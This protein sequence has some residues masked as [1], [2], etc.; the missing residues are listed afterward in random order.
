MKK[1]FLNQ[2]CHYMLYFFIMLSS[3]QHPSAQGFTNVGTEN[4]NVIYEHL[5]SAQGYGYIIHFVDKK[6]FV[7]DVTSDFC[8]LNHTVMRELNE[9]NFAKDINLI[10]PNVA[11]LDWGAANR[12]I[13]RRTNTLPERCTSTSKS[14]RSSAPFDAQYLFSVYTQTYSELYAFADMVNLKQKIEFWSNK[15]SEATTEEELVEIIGS[16]IT[17]VDDGH[18]ALWDEK[19][20]VLAF[21]DTKF[22]TLRQR[23]VQ[24]QIKNTEYAHSDYWRYK[25]YLQDR[26]ESITEGYF[27]KQTST[28]QRYDNFLF[29]HLPN[30]LRY[31]KIS[32]MSEFSESQTLTSDLNAV[33]EILNLILPSMRESNGI[34]IDLRSNPGGYDLVS[35]KILSYFIDKKLV[36]ASKQAKYLAGFTP[37]RTV[38]VAPAN[39]LPFL[40]P[41]IVL[42]NQFTTSAAEIFVL[43]LK[44]RG[45]VSFYGTRTDGA[46]SDSLIKQ[47]SNGW[48]FSLSNEVY[49][50]T[51]GVQYEMI[52]HPVSKYFEYLNI[53][54]IEQGI[55]K[56]LE[57]A[58]ADLK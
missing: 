55:D 27:A 40:G 22:N 35:L 36:V 1:V 12:L 37:L 56:A 24:A 31:F 58:I 7:Y 34:V 13:L 39:A 44:A 6:P 23:L 48:Y 16:F 46:Y 9:L 50:D 43:G 21:N 52:G 32:E 47:L 8:V 2:I 51:Q 53:K 10:A 14:Q 28:I 25:L 49:W 4:S 41:I 17:S 5:W 42:T 29:A 20:N 33:D 30:N 54:D 26:S 15:V 11:L 38:T 19:G 18:A 57:E 45:N 3:L